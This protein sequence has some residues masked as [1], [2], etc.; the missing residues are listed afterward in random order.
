MFRQLA[1]LIARPPAPPPAAAGQEAAETIFG[2]H[3]IQLSRFLEEVWASRNSNLNSITPTKLEIPAAVSQL[4]LERDSGIRDTLLQW[5]VIT[6]SPTGGQFTL[7]VT[8]P[9]GGALPTGNIAHNATAG[10]IQSALVSAGI[11]SNDVLAEGGPLPDQPVSLRFR[12]ALGPPITIP[13]LTAIVTQPFTGGTNA[14]IQIVANGAVYPPGI[15][16]HLIYAYMIE[17]T[18]VYE[19]FRRVLEEYAYGERLSVPSD[20]GQRWLRTTESLFYHDPPP[21]QIYSLMS[22]IRPDIRAVRRNAYHRMFGLDLNHGTDDNRPYPYPRAAAANTDF[23]TTFEEL[24]RETWRAIENIRN[25][26]GANPTDEAVIAHLSRTIFDMLRVRRQENVGNLARDELF[27][28]STMGW[29]HLT[30]SFNTPIV[31]DLKAEATSPAERL[32]KIGERVGLPAHSRTDSYLELATNMSL[33]LRAMENGT[34]NEVA[35]A[36]HLFTPGNAFQEAMQQI[37]AHWTIA[38]GRDLKASRV[39]V[40]PTAP[41]PVRPTSRPIAARPPSGNGQVTVSRETITT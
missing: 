22:W 20:P 32:Q 15:W 35:G 38:T 9:G 39:S 5:V 36:R 30:L 6:G 12:N 8:P 1:L 17:N 41:R 7:T 31:R 28:V 33:I 3:P 34:L 10:T 11:G 25:E 37:I 18:R 13:P 21:F 2:F 24:L 19:V 27:H 16:D 26:A 29:F 4:G 23:T 40:A 14:A